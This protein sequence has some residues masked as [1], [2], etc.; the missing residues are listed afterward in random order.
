MTPFRPAA[1]RRFLSAAGR[2]TGRSFCR[3]ITHPAMT[4]TSHVGETSFCVPEA[5]RQVSSCS[6]PVACERR[7]TFARPATAVRHTAGALPVEFSW[8]PARAV[9]FF[10]PLFSCPPVRA[11]HRRRHL[12]ESRAAPRPGGRRL[13][14]MSPVRTVPRASLPILSSNM[15]IRTGRARRIFPSHGLPENPY[16]GTG[17]GPLANGR[18]G[19]RPTRATDEDRRDRDR[20]PLKEDDAAG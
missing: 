3:R 7:Q 20:A 11:A 6:S 4:A 13:R 1:L 18:D 19:E 2:I 14:S 17:Q 15:I 5:G 16:V 12:H 9:F 8:P 10:S